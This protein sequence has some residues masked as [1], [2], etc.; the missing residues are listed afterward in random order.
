MNLT[1]SDLLDE[2]RIY[3]H[4]AEQYAV[5]SPLFFLKMGLKTIAISGRI[6]EIASLLHMYVIEEHGPELVTLK[7]PT[8]NQLLSDEILQTT[9]GDPALVFGNLSSL[10]YDALAEPVAIPPEAVMVSYLN[11]VTV[12]YFLNDPS[13]AI[14][15]PAGSHPRHGMVFDFSK[16]PLSFMVDVLLYYVSTYYAGSLTLEEKGEVSFLFGTYDGS[17]DL[18]NETYADQI[19]ATTGLDI[20]YPVDKLAVRWPDT[21]FAISYDDYENYG[22]VYHSMFIPVIGFTVPIF[23]AGKM[24]CVPFNMVF[25]RA[26]MH[27]DLV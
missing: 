10:N 4:S 22:A 24:A 20:G 17:Y 6:A 8:K 1:F 26:A 23:S 18:L 12:A 13:L 11:S 21:A 14:A 16:T 27:P 3:R 2:F 9:S 25:Q 15:E 7:V 19:Q 5:K